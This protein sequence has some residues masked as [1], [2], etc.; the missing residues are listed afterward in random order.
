MKKQTK[1]APAGWLAKLADGAK[2][3]YYAQGVKWDSA[4]TWAR[5]NWQDWWS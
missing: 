2:L 1:K 3:L 4:L 5:E